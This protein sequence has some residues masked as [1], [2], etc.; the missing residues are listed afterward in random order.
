[1]LLHGVHC[2]ELVSVPW[3]NTGDDENFK[4][5]FATCGCARFSFH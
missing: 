5:L 3:V 2:T 1:M 4:Q